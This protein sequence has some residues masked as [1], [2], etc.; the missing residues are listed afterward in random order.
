MSVRVGGR[1]GSDEVSV[2]LSLG[3]RL[4]VSAGTEAMI[5]D[6]EPRA[7]SH[8]FSGASAGSVQQ[9]EPLWSGSGFLAPLSCDRR[10]SSPRWEL[11]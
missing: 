11:A 8:A 10:G 6:F 2:A 3:R 9:F 7:D 1:P 5:G 4:V